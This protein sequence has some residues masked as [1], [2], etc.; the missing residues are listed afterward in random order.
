MR[1]RERERER[2]ERDRER[3]RESER[4]RERLNEPPRGVTALFSLQTEANQR[5]CTHML[6]QEEST[7]E[8]QERYESCT[9]KVDT[10]T[11]IFLEFVVI[12]DQQVLTSSDNLVDGIPV[13]RFGGA[14]E[15]VQSLDRFTIRARKASL[16]LEAK[17][18]KMKMKGEIE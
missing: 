17:K 2:V 14:N 6:F 3:E 10:Q 4:E 15:R 7:R 16:F 12:G 13:Q 5:D 9:K 11:Y 18:M 1:K 8:R